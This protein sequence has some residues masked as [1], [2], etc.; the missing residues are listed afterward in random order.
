MTL[1]AMGQMRKT[2][3]NRKKIKGRHSLRGFSMK[4]ITIHFGSLWNG[5]SGNHAVLEH[6]PG[7]KVGV[8][9]AFSNRHY[10]FATLG[11]VSAQL[12]WVRNSALNLTTFDL[13]LSLQICHTNNKAMFKNHES[14]QF[15]WGLLC[16]S[17]S[18]INGKQV[19]RA[20]VFVHT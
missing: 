17:D 20:S 10:S 11:L 12:L 6:Y 19:S 2:D 3:T 13:S 5:F 1:R 15:P 8:S 16:N 7:H 14:R 18:L 4:T 9:W